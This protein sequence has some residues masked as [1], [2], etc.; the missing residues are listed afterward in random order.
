[1][2]P[3]DPAT[4]PHSFS[5][6]HWP[7]W[8]EV[9]YPPLVRYTN[10]SV[11]AH[12]VLLEEGWDDEREVIDHP[13]VRRWKK[14]VSTVKVKPPRF[15]CLRMSAAMMIAAYKRARKLVGHYRIHDWSGHRALLVAGAVLSNAQL[16]YLGTFLRADRTRNTNYTALATYTRYTISWDEL[17]GIILFGNKRSKRHNT[18]TRMK[19]NNVTRA[20]CALPRSRK[21][22]SDQ[23]WDEVR[24][25]Q[26]LS[27]L[28]RKRRSEI[29]Y[30]LSAYSRDQDVLVPFE[31][32]II[33][34]GVDPLELLACTLNVVP[35]AEALVS[36]E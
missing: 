13:L 7:E 26:S 16:T 33:D 6:S 5:V 30:R 36:H 8:R 35:G 18:L 15:L 14:V 20:Y 24:T 28:D 3:A 32:L 4:M 10:Y 22:K 27:S 23:F 12:T 29:A 21:I 17:R 11:Q 9:N 25:L 34:C 19:L 2:K 31:E 1:M